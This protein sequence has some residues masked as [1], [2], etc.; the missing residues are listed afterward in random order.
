MKISQQASKQTNVEES[1]ASKL[2]PKHHLSIMNYV[3]TKL[4]FPC[5]PTQDTD[6]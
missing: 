6:S 2:L 1:T 4:A 3:W 5:S